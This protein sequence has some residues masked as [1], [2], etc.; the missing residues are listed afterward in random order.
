MNEELIP[1][2]EFLKKATL[3]LAVIAGTTG[4]MLSGG[5]SAGIPSNKK[6]V[7]WNVLQSDLPNAKTLDNYDRD[8]VN[9]K[10]ITGDEF[11]NTNVVGAT[12]GYSAKMS[13]GTLVPL[14]RA[15]ELIG[16][17]LVFIGPG[18]GFFG[19]VELRILGDL[20]K[21]FGVP[22][23]RLA[24]GNDTPI[25]ANELHIGVGQRNAQ[26]RTS[27]RIII[28]RG[29]EASTVQDLD[30]I[31]SVGIS[32][33]YQRG[34]HKHRIAFTSSTVNPTISDI[35]ND[36]VRIWKNTTNGELRIWANDSGT[37]KSVLMT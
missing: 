24:L 19:T 17:V 25:N 30:G 12:L 3:P 37:L 10:R 32:G 6:F 14:M 16:N 29:D 34:G 15:I 31:Q 22:W 35:L 28:D 13:D 36:K 4:G 11:T 2:R 18:G 33:Q 1:R 20:V 7:V 26:L 9:S 21:N 27:S 8:I 5:L 23:H